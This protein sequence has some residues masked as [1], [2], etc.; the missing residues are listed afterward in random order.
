ME[1]GAGLLGYTS[2]VMGPLYFEEETFNSNW[3][4]FVKVLDELFIADLIL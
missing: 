4:I 3:F 1:E 2:L